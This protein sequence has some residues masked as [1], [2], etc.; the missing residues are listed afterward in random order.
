MRSL[1]LSRAAGFL[2]VSAL[3]AADAVGQTPPA[4]TFRAGTLTF[5]YYELG[6]HR[7][8]QLVLLSGGPGFD[9]DYF[10][11][12]PAF[13]SLA[14]T[15]WVL[16]YDQRGTGG[17]APVGPSDRVTVADMVADLDALRVALGVEKLDLLGHSWGGYLA[18][19]YAA[20]HGDRVGHLVLVGSAAPKFSDTIFLF[21][22]VFPERDMSTPFAKG[23]ATGDT[24]LIHEGLRIYTSMIFWSPEQGEAWRKLGAKLKYNHFQSAEL[25][26]D[27]GQQDFTPALKGFRFP[28]L[29]TTGRYD[30]NVA[31]LTAYRIHQAIPDSKF[32]VF[33]KSSHIPFY[34][35]PA[36]F[37]EALREFLAR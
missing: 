6:P 28:T 19:A 29:V 5:T 3:V 8:N 24:A 14:K 11:F 37:V 17:S 7:G 21:S 33:E 36:A 30:M 31:P 15:N 20:T 27:L 23:R 34:E 12:G 13:S 32:L 16:T 35:E 2:V 22:Q 4:K 9:S 10:W 18:Q 26:K 25:Q 1:F